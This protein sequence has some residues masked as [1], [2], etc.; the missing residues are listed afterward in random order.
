MRCP[1]PKGAV[2]RAPTPAAPRSPGGASR[3]SPRAPP[4]RALPRATLTRAPL[5]RCPPPRRCSFKVAE[6]ADLR[7]EGDSKSA[8]YTYPTM[9]KKLGP[10]ELNIEGGT[11]TNSEIIVMLGQNGTGK[12]TFIKMLAGHMQ[13][14]G[15]D[16][17][18][19]P[20]LHVS[21]AA[22]SRSRDLWVTRRAHSLPC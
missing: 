10:F 5:P 18:Q 6:N 15:D 20:K 4:A 14:D 7:D 2:G 16:E 1:A 22:A 19:L 21:C 17:H 3:H 11:F 12:T 9:A 13:A 8:S